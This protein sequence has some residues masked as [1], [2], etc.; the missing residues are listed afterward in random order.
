MRF[1]A[2]LVALM[3]A[4]PALAQ[5]S[6]RVRVVDVAGGRAYLQP[7]EDRGLR[8]GQ[9]VTFGRRR[10]RVVSVTRSSAVVDLGQR[11]LRVGAR[12]RARVRRTRSATEQSGLEEVT[13]LDS[14]RGQWPDARLPSEGQSPDP[15]PLG[16]ELSDDDRIRLAAIVGGLLRTPLGSEGQVLGRAIA[17]VRLHAEPIRERPLS[18][19]VDA[20]AQL[21]MGRDVSSRPGDGSRPYVLVRRLELAYGRDASIALGRL[22]RASAFVG[23]LDG[24]RVRTPTFS[25]VSFGAFGGVIPNP[26]DGR[27]NFD[28]S[29]FGLEARFDRPESALRPV[30]ALVAH[31][32]T[33]DGIDERRLA[34]EAYLHPDWGTAGGFAELSMFR[35][36][37][38]WDAPRV[39]LTAAGV[40]FGVRAG[41]VSA[42]IHGGLRKPERSRFLDSLLPPEWT[43]TQDPQSGSPV[44]EACDGQYDARH[45]AT[46]DVGVELAE[47]YDLRVG[48][49]IAQTGTRNELDMG[50]G[51]LQFRVARIANLVHGSV[52]A[53]ASGGSLL[54]R[55]GGRLQ[56]G[57][58]PLAGKIDLT[59]HYGVGVG[60]LR[61]DQD[62]YVE[63]RAGGSLYLTVGRSW[64]FRLMAD[65]L[66]GGPTSAMIIDAQLIW[67]L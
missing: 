46:G 26:T 1:F 49:A 9:R 54:R 10:F 13:P 63:H 16:A 66:V 44:D 52:M 8:V 48:G 57:A 64:R 25:G 5:R 32:S 27:P 38:R 51:F 36:N 12:G 18:I 37:N 50:T 19:D 56:V 3:C 15:V 24:A 7:G 31:G 17:R 6:V 53:E 20:Q 45:Y 30:A 65:A 42:H 60:M 28:V 11:T 67:S 59:L 55:Y 35:P 29:R 43:C 22:R 41:P 61:A 34:A 23:T 4:T 2:L 62:L 21:W 58:G 14:F 47:R 33:F 39:D 40:D